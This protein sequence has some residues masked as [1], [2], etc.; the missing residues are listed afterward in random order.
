MHKMQRL[1]IIGTTPLV[2]Y[3]FKHLLR[4]LKLSHLE[5]ADF[6]TVVVQFWGEQAAENE[7]PSDDIEIAT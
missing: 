3:V 2:N 5:L 7:V 6:T 4:K 1:V